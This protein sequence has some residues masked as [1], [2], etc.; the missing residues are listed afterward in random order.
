M[1]K[2]IDIIVVP[3][4]SAEGPRQLEEKI[5]PTIA[6]MVGPMRALICGHEETAR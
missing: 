2:S 4:P 1:F 5:G 6:L 3:M